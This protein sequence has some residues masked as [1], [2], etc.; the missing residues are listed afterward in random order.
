[1]ILLFFGRYSNFF[2]L[3][4]IYLLSVTKLLQSICFYFSMIFWH[5]LILIWYKNQLKVE[6][7]RCN[8]KINIFN[9]CTYYDLFTKFIIRFA[10]FGI[11]PSVVIRYNH[12][13][14]FCCQRVD[15]LQNKAPHAYV[16][17]K[18][19]MCIL[20][21]YSPSVYHIQIRLFLFVDVKLTCR[22]NNSVCYLFDT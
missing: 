3:I 18:Y 9:I 7:K 8:F 14:I 2:L 12:R 1:M 5:D 16:K 21:V 20:C 4:R 10:F 11:C 13:K 15:N 17:N 6:I 22:I 19:Y